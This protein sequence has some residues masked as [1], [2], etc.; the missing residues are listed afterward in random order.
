MLELFSMM[1]CIAM[2]LECMSDISRSRLWSRMI[3]GAKTT[4][5]FLGVIWFPRIS[6]VVEKNKKETYQVFT[7]SLCDTGKMEN[8]E[9]ETVAVLGG[10]H[11]ECLS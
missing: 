10:K 2:F 8:Q 11:I 7:L 3:V 9:F 6:H 4:A 1:N 5:R